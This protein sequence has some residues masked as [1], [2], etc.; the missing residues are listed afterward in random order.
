MA[1]SATTVL[2]RP[3]SD[4]ERV[5]A[6]RPPFRVGAAP[7]AL[8]AALLAL[9]L[10]AAAEARPV[11]EAGR[12]WAAPAASPAPRKAERTPAAIAGSTG[13][14]RICA[15]IE[16]AA[17]RHGLPPSYFARL[18]W[19][20]SRFDVAAVSPVGAQG[21]AQF[22][23]GTARLEGLADPFDPEQAIPASASHLADL[24]AEFG[25]LGLAAAAYNSGR[26]R[27]SR[28]L[29]GAS[30]LPYETLDYVHSITFRPADWFCEDGR[31]VE[32]RPL[33]EDRPFAQACR[34]L[35]VMKTRALAAGAPMKPWG[36]QVAGAVTRDAAARA[37]Q[38]VAARFSAV[39]GSPQP[40]VV[41]NRRAM[42]AP[43]GARIGA[44]SRA[45]AQA[46][47]AKLARAGGACVVQRN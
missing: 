13:S 11:E 27:V 41:R 26:N 22:M 3:L 35:P 24:R 5:A 20:E 6:R 19:K 42:G 8:L 31:E 1:G 17:G 32:H 44:D 47:C 28:W 43:W 4:V 10:P 33:A 23:P 14:D 16:Q 9:A 2:P 40:I 45:E 7:R 25:N 36:V 15:L 21:I 30:G 38:R 12:P 18:I 29:S 46:L 37:F 39:I 34:D